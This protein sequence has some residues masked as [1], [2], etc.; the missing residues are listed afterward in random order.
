MKIK[1]LFE[2]RNSFT[3]KGKA[4]SSGAGGLFYPDDEDAPKIFPG[5]KKP[6]YASIQVHKVEKAGFHYRYYVRRWPSVLIDIIEETI[7]KGPIL[8]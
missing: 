6:R 8:E 3:H 2:V 4:L 5:D 1:F 7:E